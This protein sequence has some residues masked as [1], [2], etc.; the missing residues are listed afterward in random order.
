MEWIEKDPCVKFQA[1]VHIERIGVSYKKRTGEIGEAFLLVVKLRN[2]KDP[3]VF[4]CY[5]DFSYGD[6]FLL[7]EKNVVEGM[8]GNLW[9]NK[10]RKKISAPVKALAGENAVFKLKDQILV[11]N[12]AI[13]ELG[14]IGKS[15]QF[16]GK[17][18]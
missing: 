7:R 8:D 10:N 4:S 13:V 5:T 2:A 14:F 3:F 9:D 15:I 1:W 17:I 16:I 11:G 6:L 12:E 18:N